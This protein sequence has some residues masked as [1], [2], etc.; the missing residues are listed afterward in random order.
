MKRPYSFQCRIQFAVPHQSLLF[1]LKDEVS[2]TFPERTPDA[3]ENLLT[4]AVCAHQELPRAK[5]A[6][7]DS[8]IKNQISHLSRLDQDQ[9]PLDAKSISFTVPSFSRGF[10]FNAPAAFS[11]RSIACQSF[12][13]TGFR[14]RPCAITSF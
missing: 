1:S 10:P 4:G 11:A 12:Q 7:M 3:A 5:S 14:W 9:V 2:L 13:W 8:R 6:V